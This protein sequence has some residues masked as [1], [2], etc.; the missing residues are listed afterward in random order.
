MEIAVGNNQLFLVNTKNLKSNLFVLNKIERINYMR[1]LKTPKN[2]HECDMLVLSKSGYLTEIEIKRSWADFLADFKKEHKHDGRGLIKYIF[3]CVPEGLLEKVYEKL[4]EQNVCYTG[5]VTYDEDLNIKR[6]GCRV[7]D[8][9]GVYSC[10]FKEI[11]PY[12]KLF[13]E[14]QLQ[15]AQCGAMRVV[16]LK[17]KIINGFWVQNNIREQYENNKI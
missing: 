10:H 2:R 16:G 4:E 14:E 3:Y 17:E 7:K 12:R 15:V 6:H 11:H 5:I 8:E 13:L 9:D 1:T